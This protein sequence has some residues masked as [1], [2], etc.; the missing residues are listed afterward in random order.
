[1]A[2]AMFTDPPLGHVG[3]H[4]HEAQKLSD[5]GRNI[6]IAEHDMKDVS[7]A[8]EESELAGRIRI[9]VDGDSGQI[10]GATILGING[11]EIVQA[12]SNFI[13]AG[14]HWSAMRDALPVHPTVTEF[15]PTIL[16]KLKPL[17][18]S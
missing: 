14:G 8:K 7:R 13:A 16:A 1:M 9:I 5:E 3:I 12:F 10:L 18:R 11:D 17:E 6:L 2:Y 4:R 15:I